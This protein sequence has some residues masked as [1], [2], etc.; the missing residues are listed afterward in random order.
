[1]TFDLTGNTWSS[2]VLSREEMCRQLSALED[3]LNTSIYGSK[4]KI[5]ILMS[6]SAYDTLC[7]TTSRKAEKVNSTLLF[8]LPVVLSPFLP[9]QDSKGKMIHAVAWVQNRIEKTIC[10]ETKYCLRTV[11]WIRP[12]NIESS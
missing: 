8:D 7:E 6:Q 3:A 11:G 9:Y 2:N 12:R 10:G 5:T 4:D 1:M